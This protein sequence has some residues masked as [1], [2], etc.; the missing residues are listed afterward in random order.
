M[1]RCDLILRSDRVVLEDTVQA[2]A[3]GIEGGRIA[4][5]AAKS[6]GAEAD[7]DIDFGDRYIFP[8]AV[9]PHVHFKEPGPNTHREDWESG[10]RQAAAG[11]VTT[12]IEMPLS[13]PLTVNRP[14][15]EAKM[16]IA[17]GK[18]HVDFALWAGMNAFAEG[19]YR[20]L[21]DL[22][23]VAYK[24]FLSTDPDSPRL[25]DY[26]FLRALR[27]VASFGGLVGV[28]AENYDIIDNYCEKFRKENRGDGRAHLD[29]RPDVAEMEAV[30]RALLFARETGARM[31]ICHLSSAKTADVMRFHRGRGADF[32][33]ET[34]H[35]YLTLDDSDLD[36]CG[37]R[38]KCN[39]PIR[40]KANREALWEMIMDGDIQMVA[41]D[42]SPYV[43]ADR[44]LPLWESPPGLSGVDL[45]FP[46]MLDE[47]LNRRGLPAEELA[48]LISTNAARRFGLYPQKG[49]IAVGSDADLA[50]V[51]P[52][53]EWAWSW[54]LSLGKSREKATPFE[55]RTIRG[56][57]LETYVRGVKV[58]DG[59]KNEVLARPGFGAFVR[60]VRNEDG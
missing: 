5:L 1:K 36:R 17:A 53:A 6:L 39:P 56:R 13:I 3:I 19:H 21:G 50:V 32:T 31:H 37:T 27:E 58:Y 8:G 46:L 25:G 2:L 47:G 43:D 15:F 12:V 45:A 40:D 9:D 16:D 24:V 10:T 14:A 52:D 48:G 51:D 29:S 41:S 35:S 38:A 49:V 34:C 11:G 22:G 55:G 28:H 60:P 7:R 59:L 57:I 44:E 20:E 23:A 30:Q 18:A 33:V 4:F 26:D 42:H 54:R